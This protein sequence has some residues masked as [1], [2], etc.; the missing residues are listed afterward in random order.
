MSEIRFQTTEK[1]NLT[2]LSYVLLSTEPLMTDFKTVS[3]SV[4]GALLFIEVQRVIECVK[5]SKYQQEKGATAACT[6]RI[7]EATKGIGHR[8][9]KG[10]T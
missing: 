6:K 7:M 8:Y 1:G 4:A 2:H 3:C 9:R 5:Y 10:A